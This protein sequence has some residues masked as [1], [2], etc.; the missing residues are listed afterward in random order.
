MESKELNRL[1][2]LYYSLKQRGER[3][4]S[5][6]EFLNWYSENLKLG[7]FYCGIEIETQTKI[8]DSG[9]LI[10]NRF[11]THKYKSKSGAEKY[12]TRGNSFE[13]D[14]KKP[15]GAY[16]VENCVL[17]CY[18]CNNDKSDVFSS[19]QYIAFIGSDVKNKKNNPRYK[20]L[21]SLLNYDEQRK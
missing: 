12:G 9:K 13:V 10:S 5:K 3:Q 16:S 8:I 15:K 19:E 6:K 7:C 2:N 18:F 21:M 1:T 17:C 20:Y 14:R 4:F 11:F